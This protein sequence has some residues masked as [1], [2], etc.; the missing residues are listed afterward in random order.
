MISF[1]D[2][3]NVMLKQQMTEPRKQMQPGCLTEKLYDFQLHKGSSKMKLLKFDL[4]V[5]NSI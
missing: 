1:P 2:H 4:L 3:A 5:I